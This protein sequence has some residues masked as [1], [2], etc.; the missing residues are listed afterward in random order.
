MWHSQSIKKVF[1][2]N[3]KKYGKAKTKI[4]SMSDITRIQKDAIKHK[5]YTVRKLLK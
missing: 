3:V 1:F 5:K 4:Y 2:K